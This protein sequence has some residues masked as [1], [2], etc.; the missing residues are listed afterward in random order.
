MTKKSK[1]KTVENLY[2]I[3]IYYISYVLE[4]CVSNNIVVSINSSF[5]SSDSPLFFNSSSKFWFL[6]NKT[7]FLHILESISSPCIHYE[8]RIKCNI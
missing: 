4:N 7:P 2:I 6:S 3:D 1:L 8:Q 5:L